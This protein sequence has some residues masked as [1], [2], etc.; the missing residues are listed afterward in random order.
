MSEAIEPTVDAGFEEVVDPQDEV[1]IEQEADLDEGVKD[2]VPAE[3]KQDPE[4]NSKFAEMRRRAEAADAR[5]KKAD[6]VVA[7]QWGHIGVTTVEQLEQHLEREARQAEEERWRD[8]GL[9]PDEVQ[10]LIDEKLENH[11]D[12]LAAKKSKQESFRATQME[13]LNKTYGLDIKT[14]EDIQ[15]LPNAEAMIQKIVAG[16]EWDEAYLV[17]HQDH[18]TQNLAS[19]AKQS[20]LNNQ[21]S[22]AHLKTTKGGSDVDTFTPDPEVMAN[23]RSMFRKE[24]RQG[25][26]TEKDLI[27]HYRKSISK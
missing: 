21:Q 2:S 18:I 16:Y 24:L 20:A 25:K 27:T 19:R 1:E 12:V 26:M 22:K 14:V 10:K 3:Q 8:M 5:A 9:E 7:K 15:N 6:D 17:T 11:P 13:K 4:L 23:Y